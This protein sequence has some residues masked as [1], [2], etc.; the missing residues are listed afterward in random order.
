MSRRLLHISKLEHF[1][2]WLDKEGIA[3]R[4]PRGDYQVL[5][6]CKNGKNWNCVYSR[7]DMPEHYTT[8]R[9][10]D[11]LVIKFARELRTQ[12]EHR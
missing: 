4:P 3:H 9:H 5:Q 11:N 2:Q 12:N 10:L 1:K 7:H 8:D 6:V